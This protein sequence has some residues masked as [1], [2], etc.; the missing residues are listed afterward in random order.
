MILLKINPQ[1]NNSLIIIL[2]KITMLI[3]IIKLI[4]ILTLILNINAGDNLNNPCL[5]SNTLFGQFYPK[6][7]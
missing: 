4:I 5:P 3:P 1:I 2:I 6:N 7:N